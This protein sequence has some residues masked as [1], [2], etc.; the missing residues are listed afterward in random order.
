[1]MVLTSAGQVIFSLTPLF[2]RHPHYLAVAQTVFEPEM[3]HMFR[4][5]WMDDKGQ[6]QINRGYRVQFSNALGPYKGGLRFHP[7]VDL[8][9]VKF[10]AFEQVFKNA[11]TGLPIGGGKGG[12]DFDPKGKSEVEIMRFCQAFMMGLQHYVGPNRDVPAGDIGV[13]A[14]ELGYMYGMYKRLTGEYNGVLTGKDV[15]WGG[16]LLRPEATGYGVVYFAQHLL[17]GAG[18]SI[19]GLACIVS[20]S[21]N[22]S[23]FCAQKL[24]A[25]GAKVPLN[26]RLRAPPPRSPWLC[27][28][29]TLVV[30]DARR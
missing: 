26:F 14:R 1:M 28:P 9:V 12:S 24:I 6:Q 23:T 7:S 22:V 29:L 17:G 2:Q 16:S 20:G 15:K 5:T 4:V 18:K 21:G 19:E 13:G 3:Q 25:K 8:S 11:L 10:L 30:S 27:L